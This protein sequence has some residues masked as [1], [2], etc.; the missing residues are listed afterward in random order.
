MKCNNCGADNTADAKFCNSCGQGLSNGATDLLTVSPDSIENPTIPYTPENYSLGRFIIG[1]RFKV[2]KKLGKGGMGEVLLAEDV[3]LKRNVAI[4]SIL[5]SN[6]ADTNSKIRFLRE[7]QTASQLDHPNIC[8]IY[9]VYEENDTD[10]I[11][12]QYVDGVTLDQIIGV[13][14]LSL[15]KTIDIAIQICGGMAEAHTRDV[16]H[17][18]IKPGNIMIDNKGVV[19]ILDFG[20]AKFNVGVTGRNSG[21]VD[22]NLTEKGFVMG[23][24]AYISPEQ[25]KGKPLDLRSDIFSFGIVLYEL[26]EGKNPFKEEEQIETLYNVLNKKVQFTCD[27]PEPL[28][29]IVL[30]A[31]EKNKE[32]RYADFF[33]LKQDLETFRTEFIG[34]SGTVPMEAGRQTE[35]I[36]LKEQALFMK[37]IKRNSDKED[38]GALVSRIKRFK[39]STAQMVPS[40]K[41]KHKLLW[42][43][44]P[45][46]VILLAVV[47]YFVFGLNHNGKIDDQDNKI[48]AQNKDTKV[49]ANETRRDVFYIYLHQFEDKTGAK[50]LP[51]MVD[52]LLMESLNQFVEFK[53]IN[54]DMVVSLFGEGNE[55]ENLKNLNMK[56]KI[57]YELTGKISR[58][59]NFYTIDARLKPYDA[60]DTTKPYAPATTG[61]EKDSLLANQ[62]D[63]LTQN[64]YS[65]LFPQKGKNYEYFK[66]SAVFGNRWDAYV[67]IYEGKPFWKRRET[68]KALSYFLKVEEVLIA[69][70]YLADL[71]LFDGKGQKSL[72]EIK[73]ILPYIGSLSPALQLKV[74]ALE[75]R[76]KFLFNDEIA[77]LK[78]LVEMFPFDKEAFY[79]LGEAYFHHAAPVEAIQYY[80]QALELDRQ[81]S[82]ALNHQGYCYAYLGDHIKA[83]ELFQDYRTLDETSNSFD[84]LG[85]G[86]FFAGDLANAEAMKRRAGLPDDK[87]N[88]NPYPFQTLADIYILKAD[89]TRSK[90]A[91]KEFE[92]MQNSKSD[93]A[94]VLS[95]N[96][97]IEYLN[98]CYESALTLINQSLTTFDSNNILD[99]TAE[100]H[101]LKGVILVTAQKISGAKEQLNWLDEFKKKYNLDVDNF[102][103]AVK[104]GIHLR[105]L[106]AEQ[107]NHLAEAEKEYKTLIV[108]KNRLSYWISYFYY[109][110]FHT[111]YVRFL[112]RGARYEEALKEVN[113]CLEF[114]GAYIPALWAKAEILER[115]KKGA[116]SITAIYDRIA[117]LHGESTESNYYRDLLKTKRR[118]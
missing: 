101:W 70:Y 66:I 67:N 98:L 19:K 91:L 52:Q 17:R 45:G 5:K 60:S 28:Q 104:F 68:G 81:Y 72:E 9:E 2:L 107:E 22:V 6:L 111:E 38:L 46:L 80:D 100:A 87:N 50:E 47:L 95:R 32:A 63:S 36:D 57:K 8:T 51:A 30:K 118:R 34:S 114:N 40:Q 35:I 109:P 43:A 62:I 78:Q 96:A 4:K 74:R 44:V 85:D 26:L 58:D 103:A 27:V 88:R 49:A 33:K 11:V 83:L 3:K 64:I 54:K 86:Y 115:L 94:Y 69:K 92:N 82:Q 53:T 73:Q 77:N 108:I 29:R 13:K 7:A 31:L 116:S 65:H 21:Q 93:S 97:F 113:V 79:Q 105:A 75:G 61:P 106:I 23:T 12:M 39:A 48:N 1:E 56:F 55:R 112:L 20:L 24:I 18:D 110:Y 89:Y 42:W 16:I 102:N 25:A 117:Q 71:Y 15:D 59:S 76:L 10:Y 99:N 41:R 14:T 84:S 90:E 37:E